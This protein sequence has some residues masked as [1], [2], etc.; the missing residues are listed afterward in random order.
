MLILFY[1][2]GCPYCEKVISFMNEKDIVADKKDISEQMHKDDLISLTNRTQV[3]FLVD[4]NNRTT[5]HES[6][7][8]IKYLTGIAKE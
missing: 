7:D 2:P 6:E 8:I 5:L 1:L 4:E 3:P